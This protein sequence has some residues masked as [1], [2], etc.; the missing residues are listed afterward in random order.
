MLYMRDYSLDSFEMIGLV[1]WSYLWN[2]VLYKVDHQL[3]GFNKTG[4]LIVFHLVCFIPIIRIC[5]LDIETGKK[6]MEVCI[7]F[8]IAT[9]KQD[10]VMRDLVQENAG[11]VDHKLVYSES[12]T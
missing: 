12:E 4:N 6:V 7:S 11:S 10:L 9:L 2:F 1:P 8:H 5:K 3:V